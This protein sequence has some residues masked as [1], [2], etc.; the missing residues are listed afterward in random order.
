MGG[1][2]GPVEGRRAL[3]PALP[4]LPTAPRVMCGLRPG[5][6]GMGAG[7]GALYPGRTAP[8]WGCPGGQLACVSEEGAPGCPRSPGS[9]ESSEGHLSRGSTS[10]CVSLCRRKATLG[11]PVHLGE[12]R[13]QARTVHPAIDSGRVGCQDAPG[14]GRWQSGAGA[15]Q[16][17]GALCVWMGVQEQSGQGGISG[18][19]SEERHW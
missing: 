6:P 2:L 14:S 5:S 18:E 17:D 4:P 7:W 9:V 11:S 13:G 3:A 10:T 8:R 12:W 16:L 1:L 15:G 19:R